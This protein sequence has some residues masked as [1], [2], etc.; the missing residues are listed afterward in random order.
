[1]V[2]IGTTLGTNLTLNGVSI[3]SG[4][5]NP[6][7]KS[8]HTGLDID[9][10]TSPLE[11]YTGG[12]NFFLEH[13][14]GGKWY[15]AAPYIGQE[16]QII[17]LNGSRYIAQK[18]DNIKDWDKAV[19]GSDF[20]NNKHVLEHKDIPYLLVD[21]KNYNYNSQNVKKQIDA[22]IDTGS[23]EQVL[24]NDLVIGVRKRK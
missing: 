19:L 12:Q 14:H 2:I 18:I 9:I 23:V 22:F 6:Y 3:K 17:V 11:R 20:F 7:H 1:M 4:G 8:H 21:N 15:V 13:Q 10:D 24:H 16:K 5:T